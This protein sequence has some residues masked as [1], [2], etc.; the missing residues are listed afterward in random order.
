MTHPSPTAEQLERLAFL[1]RNIGDW[2]EADA[3]DVCDMATKAVQ[4]IAALEAELAEKQDQVFRQQGVF[5]ELRERMV[6]MEAQLATHRADYAEVVEAL[7][8]LSFSCFSP[9]GPA[10]APCVETYNSTF[11]VYEKHKLK[12]VRLSG[13]ATAEQRAPLPDYIQDSLA[14]AD[15]VAELGAATPAPGETP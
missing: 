6:Q 2:T 3:A 11:A 14:K 5:N 8:R 15:R 1:R 7:E 9:I 4:Q 10:Q 12:L 13:A